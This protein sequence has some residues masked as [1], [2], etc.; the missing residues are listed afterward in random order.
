MVKTFREKS[1]V[2]QTSELTTVE[3]NIQQLVAEQ[4]Q[5]KRRRTTAGS[6]KVWTHDEEVLLLSIVAEWTT[7]KPPLRDFNAIASRQR[8]RLAPHVRPV[9]P[10]IT[11][12]ECEEIVELDI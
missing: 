9:C 1:L 7:H 12:Q 11:Y 5:Q 2:S 4:R 10:H 6:G 3:P 8:S